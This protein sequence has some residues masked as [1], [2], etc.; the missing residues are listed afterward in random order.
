MKTTQTLYENTQ[1]EAE[2]HPDFT[3]KMVLAK[4]PFDAAA[5]LNRTR[6]DGS[7]YV[8][9]SIQ[10]G[11]DGERIKLSL[12]QRKDR[13]TA[14]DPQFAGKETVA[15]IPYRFSAWLEHDSKTGMH[16]LRIEADEVS[17]DQLTPAALASRRKLVG[18]VRE[19]AVEVEDDDPTGDPGP[20]PD[21]E[22]D[23]ETPF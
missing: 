14:A 5:W 23:D 4:T 16:R 6:K 21:E 7:P 2:D 20:P 1:K 12:W 8:G 17:A 18:F 19:L 3:G 9:M 10:A 13:K 22:P 11:K 15:G